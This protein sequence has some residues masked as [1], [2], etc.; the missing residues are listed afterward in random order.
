MCRL[1]TGEYQKKSRL[2]DLIAASF[3]SRSRCDSAAFAA[4]T[5]GV[6]R[7]S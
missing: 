3:W 4:A 6:M 1:S 5:L 2:F 7:S